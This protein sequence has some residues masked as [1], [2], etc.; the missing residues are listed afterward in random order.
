M[1]RGERKQYL[2]RR[3]L[4]ALHLYSH[5]EY[6]I[7]VV[8]HGNEFVHYSGVRP[9]YWRFPFMSPVDI[10]IGDTWTRSSASGQRDRAIRAS[11][12]SE[13]V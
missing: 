3:M 2:L 4:D 10:H 9:K 1:P 8:R 6:G 5:R 7:F 11:R 12:N 13:E